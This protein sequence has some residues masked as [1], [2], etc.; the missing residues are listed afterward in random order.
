MSESFIPLFVSFVKYNL[1]QVQC[2]YPGLPAGIVADE[3]RLRQ[4][5]INLLSNALKFTDHGGVTFKVEVISND[6]AVQP[7]LPR[8][9]RDQQ[10][11]EV[12]TDKI[13]PLI[14]KAP[15]SPMVRIRFQIE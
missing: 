2:D 10:E 11:G 1:Y 3:K 5:L 6:K 4:V 9:Y 7:P 15:E 14:G 8:I 13:M 12:I